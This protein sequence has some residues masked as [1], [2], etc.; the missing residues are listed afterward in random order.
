MRPDARSDVGDDVSRGHTHGLHDVFDDSRC[1]PAP[2]RVGDPHALARAIA[3]EDRQAVGSHHRA[4]RAWALRHD[5]IGFCVWCGSRRVDHG[6]TV[7]LLHPCGLV[8]QA[9]PQNGAVTRHA[10]RIIA[11]SHAQI[12]AGEFPGAHSTFARGDERVHSPLRRPIGSDPIGV[13]QAPHS[14]ESRSDRRS[15]GKGTEKR[16]STPETGCEN[17]RRT[18]CKA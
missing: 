10:T 9:C 5:S 1:K 4:D 14:S 2:A 13:R 12:E 7:H 18:A 11:N 17:P 6:R 3:E 15:S 16:L 8:W